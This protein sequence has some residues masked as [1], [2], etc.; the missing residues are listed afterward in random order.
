MNEGA[1][2]AESPPFFFMVP[3]QLRLFLFD[4]SFGVVLFVDENTEPVVHFLCHR[5]LAVR[6][7]FF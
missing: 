3:E 2:I 4:E 7:Y 5:L 6:F 1:L